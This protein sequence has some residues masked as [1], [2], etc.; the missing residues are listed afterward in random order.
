MAFTLVRCW[1][2]IKHTFLIW[3]IAFSF[4]ISNNKLDVMGSFDTFPLKMPIFIAILYKQRDRDNQI[5]VGIFHRHSN[6][7]QKTP[8]NHCT[9]FIVFSLEQKVCVFVLFD[10]RKKSHLKFLSIKLNGFSAQKA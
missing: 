6:R 7:P 10:T 3:R 8:I 2:M 5:K 9:S 1:Q 4:G